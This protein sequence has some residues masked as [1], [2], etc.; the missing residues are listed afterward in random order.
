MGEGEIYLLPDRHGDYQ[1]LKNKLLGVKHYSR[2]F[3]VSIVLDLIAPLWRKY[4]AWF[5]D[6]GTEAQRGHP[7]P[8]VY[9]FPLYLPQTR[10]DP[11]SLAIGWLLNVLLAHM[12]FWQMSTKPLLCAK[13]SPGSWLCIEEQK[14]F[15]PCPQG[16]S[17]HRNQLYYFL[18]Q[19]CLFCSFR[20]GYPH[21]RPLFGSC[22]NDQILSKIIW[23]LNISLSY[24]TSPLKGY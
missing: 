7:D 13:T 18:T 19:E 10:T 15:D 3:Y 14:R 23:K 17:G 5:R 8:K 20:P 4:H 24:S 21:F 6:K 1:H 12:P 22:D 16:V 2:H 11:I 9:A